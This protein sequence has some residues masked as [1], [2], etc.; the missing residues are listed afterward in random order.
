MTLRRNARIAG[1]AFLF[2]IA[3]GVTQMVLGPPEGSGGDVGE[4]LALLAQHTV[5]AKIDILLTLVMCITAATLAVALFGLTRDVDRDLA[6]LALSFRLGEALFAAL[7]LGIALGQ[8]WLA[9]PGSGASAPDPDWARSFGAY[10]LKLGG[11]NV[12][13]SATLF[14]L[15]STV[16]CALLLR[17]RLIPVPFAWLGVAASVLLVVVLPLQLV[18]WVR[19]PLA[20]LVW[21]PMAVFEVPLGFWLMLKG[22]R[23]A[24]AA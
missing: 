4:R 1:F 24:V 2:Y 6:V 16:Y 21:A 8:L 11:W 13:I 23:A 14:A 5:E 22:T 15:G 3:I 12:T 9:V 10:L 18:G 19:G 17:G 20:M 7:A